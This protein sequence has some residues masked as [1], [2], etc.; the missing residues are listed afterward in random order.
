MLSHPPNVGMKNL[1]KLALIT[2][3]FVALHLIPQTC[4][5]PLTYQVSRWTKECLYDKLEEDEF[6]T[7]SLFISHGKPLIANAI[8]EG[9]VAPVEAETGKD[10]NIALQKFNAGTRFGVDMS[11]RAKREGT[12]S[13]GNLRIEESVDFENLDREGEPYQKTVQVISPGWYRVCAHAT[14]SEVSVE[15]EMRKSSELGEPDFNTGHVPTIE[16][17]IEVIEEKEIEA[18]KEEDLADAKKHIKNLKRTLNDIRDLQNK[19]KHRLEQHQELNM[20]SHS[21][22]VVNSL[23]ETALF[24]GVTGFQVYTIRKWFQGGPLLG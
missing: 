24:I 7:L 13:T 3:A 21:R 4:G 23:L 12:D 6:V 8:I 22:M 11:N 18:A 5:L 15:L 19:E 10:L 1:S 17:N 20:H 2:L 14:N 9:P 16:S